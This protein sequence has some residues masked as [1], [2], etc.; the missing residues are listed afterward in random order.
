MASAPTT[1]VRRA[2]PDDLPTL[3]RFG[4]AL[5]RQHAA[6]DGRRFTLPEPLEAACAAFFAEQLGSADA[7][8]LVAEPADGSAPVG[9]ALA[10]REPASFVDALPPSGWV[11]DLYVDPGAR[12]LGAGTALLDAAVAALR[13]AGAD[14]VL[15][16]VAPANPAA[17]RVF[18]GRGFR[19][20]MHEMALN[21]A[22]LVLLLGGVT[23]CG[24]EAARGDP[25]RVAAGTASV[26]L[27]PMP[28]SGTP[29]EHMDMGRA[30]LDTGPGMRGGY[31]A[32]G[33]ALAGDAR[34]RDG[35]RHVALVIDAEGARRPT[36]VTVAVATT[37][38]AGLSA[39]WLVD[40]RTRAA[41]A[42]DDLMIVGVGAT[43][44]SAHLALVSGDPVTVVA[45]TA[46]AR[47]LAGPL[48]V[49][50]GVPRGVLA[51]G[52]AGPAGRARDASAPDTQAL[53]TP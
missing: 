46:D 31:C 25:T 4:A 48:R 39:E 7:A 49:G 52:A 44:S 2:G 47:I 50:S 33:P 38:R 23:A 36:R 37:E 14:I 12:G 11:H 19:T 51:W 17:R 27:A 8:L 32:V 41:C 13:T 30:L 53:G 20:T 21:V 3:T 9:Y 5:A 22:A 43:G 35:A 16:T 29:M 10:R 26:G 40:G 18:E 6:Y 1:R 15:L 28:P 45:R 24:G 34:G 42:G